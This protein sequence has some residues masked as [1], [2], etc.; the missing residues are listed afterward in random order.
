MQR[1]TAIIIG[2]STNNTLSVIRSLGKRKVKQNLILVCD[3]DFCNV[4]KSKYLHQSK[5]YEIKEIEEAQNILENI[6]T[7][8]QVII[9]TFDKA[10]M[11]V[12][13]NEN[14]LSQKFVTPCQGKRIGHLFN[15]KSQC[16]LA[17]ECGLTIPKSIVYKR[18]TQFPTMDYPLLLK[19]L[20]SIKGEK[21]DIHICF[22]DEDLRK[23]MDE[24]SLCADFIVQEYIEKDYELDCI[25][26]STDDD[27]II[28]GAVR[29][30]RHY[31]PSIGAGAYGKFLP[32]KEIDIDANAVKRFIQKSNYHGPFSVEFLHTCDNKNYFMEVNFRNEGLAYASTIAGANLHAVY[33]NADLYRPE[34]VKSVYMMNYS[35]DYLYVKSGEVSFLSWL[36]DFIRTKCFINFSIKDPM[37]TIKYYISK[38]SKK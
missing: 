11:W 7:E 9:C 4:K 32:L 2:D 37:P 6:H 8:G 14:W 3:E 13:A 20:V 33:L 23:S 29:K 38:F 35:L 27:V 34:N 16:Q 12:D 22:N 21:S 18:G 5:I 19:P 31:P 25:G 26:V 10:A 1:K 15:K 17:E 28:S 24:N 30:I 36:R